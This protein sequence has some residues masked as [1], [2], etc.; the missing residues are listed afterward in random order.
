MCN[1]Y[2]A[3]GIILL[4]IPPMAT[5]VRADLGVSRSV[6]GFALGAWALLYIVT[7]TPAGRVID[8]FGVRRSVTAGSL[9]IATSAAVQAVAQN[10]AMLWLAIGIIGVGGPLISLSAPK[11]V[12]DWFTDGRERAKAVGFYTSAPAIGGLFALALTNSVLVPVFGGWREVL[13]FEAALNLMAAATWWIVSRRAPSAPGAGSVAAAPLPAWAASKALIAA[14]GVRLAMLLGIGAFFITQGLAA[15]LPDMLE[16]HSGLSSASAS[17][18]AAASLAIGIV[19]R[20]AVPGLARPERRSLVLH[21]VMAALAVAMV[22]MAFGPTGSH[23]PAALVIGLRS[24]LNSLVILV[25]MEADQVTSANAGLAYGLWFSAVEVG[26][27]SGP[28]IVG[29]FGDAGVGYTGALVA[30]AAML[31]VMMCVLFRADRA[32]RPARFAA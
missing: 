29:A 32:T 20:L 25:L 13:A 19:A 10:G 23:V 28:P 11:L 26:G 2:F 21:A 30:M 3:F 9:L 12:G 8:R 7:A 22:V 14:P 4:A 17:N 16:E 15:W 1:V 5:A 31:A 27:A 24:T 6:L 18:W